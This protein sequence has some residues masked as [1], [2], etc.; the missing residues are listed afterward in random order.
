[1]MATCIFLLFRATVSHFSIDDY[2]D[3]SEV[4]MPDY[5]GS[6]GLYRSLVKQ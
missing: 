4:P 1:M 5:Y 6:K 3:V 2:D